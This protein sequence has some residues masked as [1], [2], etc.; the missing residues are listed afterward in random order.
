MPG[1][2][3]GADEAEEGSGLCLQRGHHGGHPPPA[4]C[5][6]ERGRALPRVR[7]RRGWTIRH[8]VSG[9]WIQIPLML[10]FQGTRSSCCGH[11]M[12]ASICILIS[13]QTSNARALAVCRVPADVFWRMSFVADNCGPLHAGMAAPSGRARCFCSS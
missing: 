11:V 10:F 6:G 13:H 5:A 2:A 1:D 7:A 8:G 4:A 12:P 9:V 3:P